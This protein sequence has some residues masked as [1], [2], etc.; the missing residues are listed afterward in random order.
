MM[1]E[2][3]KQVKAKIIEITL[4]IGKLFGHSDIKILINCQRD[5]AANILFPT[6]IKVSGFILIYSPIKDRKTVH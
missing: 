6:H 5:V 1:L 4:G 2:T 3:V